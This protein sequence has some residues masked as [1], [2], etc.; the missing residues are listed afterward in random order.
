MG[1]TGKD[2]YCCICLD[3]PQN[4]EIHPYC[5]N[6]E[7]QHFQC[8]NC[9]GYDG[10]HGAKGSQTRNPPANAVSGFAPYRSTQQST[11]S[12][13]GQP[14]SSNPA[15]T[16]NPS[17]FRQLNP[18]SER[19]AFSAGGKLNAPALI[20]MSSELSQFTERRLARLDDLKTTYKI[21]LNKALDKYARQ[22]PSQQ[23]Q[24]R[25]ESSFERYLRDLTRPTGFA[26]AWELC[27]LPFLVK[28]LPY[29]LG[30]GYVINVLCA[31][32]KNS[33][34]TICF[35]SRRKTS[36]IRRIII[37]RHVLD[38]IPSEFHNTT[39]FRFCE[40]II[41]RLGLQR[42]VKDSKHLDEAC[43]AKNPYYYLEPMMGDSTGLSKDWSAATLGP[44]VKIGDHF[45]WLANLHPFIETWKRE[46][47]DAKKCQ[48]RHPGRLDQKIC[49]HHPLRHSSSKYLILG[50]LCAWSGDNLTTTRRSS[51]P[52]WKAIEIDPP[53]VVTDWVL[54]SN[55]GLGPNTLRI[56]KTSI[57]EERLCPYVT[58]VGPAL[59]DAKVDS[60]GRTSG[61]QQGKICHIP[62]YVH[63]DRDQRALKVTREWFIEQP[64]DSEMSEDGWL[65]N[66]PGLL[67]DSG[68]PVVDSNNKTLYGQLWGRN[69]Y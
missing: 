62:A 15:Q 19:L 35:T 23:S 57:D 50:K 64:E 34:R 55:T 51:H 16:V 47:W 45:Y 43:D 4:I 2:W 38:V 1:V 37:A 26:F 10:R 63:P 32:V 3:G 68:A 25:E 30:G 20:G 53:E 22:T 48:V 28:V 8:P 41:E 12:L 36:R 61:Y 67:G 27:V 18:A 52:I 14:P 58:T 44:R 11:S 5:S 69:K 40:G 59:P 60:T 66:G 13:P 46:N 6:G 7:C 65:E 31:S 56:P 54:I 24:A 39:S 21:T 42:R 49:R 33:G 17:N 29:W 9:V